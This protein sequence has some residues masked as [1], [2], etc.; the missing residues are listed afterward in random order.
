MA[1]TSFPQGVSSFGVPVLG[2]GAN[3]PA[4][5]G[6]Y[7]FVNSVTGSNGNPGNVPN[8]P[9]ASIASARTAATANNGDVIICMPGH[10][11]TIT[12]AAGIALSKAGLY[13]VGLGTGSVRPTITLS[14]STAAQMTV[15]GANV[16]IDNFILDFTGI[17]A[18]VAAVSITAAD[19]AFVNC[20][21]R[22]N[23][24]TAGCVLGLVTAATATRFRVE[25]CFFNGPAIN[26]GTTTTAQIKHE[27][28]I[29]YIIRNNVFLGGKVTQNILNATTI[30][31]GLIDNNRFVTYTG[32][33]GIAVAAASTPFITNNRFNV[34]SGTAPIVAAA[35][36]VAGNI[37]SAAAGVTAG[38]ASTI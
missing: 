26:A 15:A 28:G 10:T 36:F 30:L 22:T 18:I 8:L 9:F 3:I 32:T 24:A 5:T 27:V 37:Y 34:P 1:L 29:D 21:V 6:N 23:N 17:D 25:N 35:G 33:K 13:I 4:T 2:S 20:E 12:G 16:T 19:V 11:E 14:T 31:G 7:W 38:T